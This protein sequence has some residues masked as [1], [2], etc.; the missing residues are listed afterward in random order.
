[1]LEAVRVG[2]VA[3]ADQM[4]IDTKLSTV[5]RAVSRAIRFAVKNYCNKRPDVIVV[6]HRAGERSRPIPDLS[7]MDEDNENE[8]EDDEGTTQKRYP[9]RNMTPTDV[10]PL[11][12][13]Y[14]GPGPSG[15]SRHL[16]RDAE[17]Q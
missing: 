3:A 14:K 7:A 6:A 1:M 8:D 4:P 2:A 5:E 9:K 16:R 12:G 15:D 13:D 17:Y 11:R 10:R